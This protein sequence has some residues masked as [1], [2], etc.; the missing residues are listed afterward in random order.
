M[1]MFNRQTPTP[2]VE[3]NKIRAFIY[4]KLAESEWGFEKL[5]DKIRVN[6]SGNDMSQ[7]RD[8]LNEFV[9]DGSQSDHRYALSYVRQCRDTRGYG[10]IKV[11]AKLME[12]KIASHVIDEV[13]Y[14]NHEIWTLR[15]K[16]ARIKKFNTLPDN[17]KEK[18]KQSRFLQQRGF[19]FSQI[20]Q[21][22][23]NDIDDNANITPPEDEE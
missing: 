7:C 19:S 8:I 14:A 11:K 2:P 9:E 13:L 23:N 12:H 22:F 6:F 17:A 15:A 4:R 18:A 10:P 1:E 16:E 21:S 5:L 20:N 3:E